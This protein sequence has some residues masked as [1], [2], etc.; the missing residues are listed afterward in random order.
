MSA[1]RDTQTKTPRKDTVISESRLEV[2]LGNK[3]IGFL[4]LVHS[5]DQ[6]HRYLGCDSSWSFLP[7]T[8]G[9]EAVRFSIVFYILITSWNWICIE[10]DANHIALLTSSCL[11]NFPLPPMVPSEWDELFMGAELLWCTGSSSCG[12]WLIYVRVASSQQPNSLTLFFH[13]LIKV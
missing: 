10:S 4:L 8:W 9:Q 13:L 3:K 12:W 11:V 6:S 7:K 1:S 2:T 5:T